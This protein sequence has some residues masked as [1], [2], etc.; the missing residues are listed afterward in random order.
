MQNHEEDHIENHTSEEC[1]MSRCDPNRPA[2]IIPP[3]VGVEYFR[4]IGP[5][6]RD[7]MKSKQCHIHFFKKSEQ[8]YDSI[9]REFLMGSRGGNFLFICKSPPGLLDLY[10]RFTGQPDRTPED[11]AKKEHLLQ[12]LAEDL[13]KIADKFCK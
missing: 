2:L 5:F 1:D 3:G 11:K 8:G 4:D 10:L 9:P 12:F 6:P 13:D 7:A